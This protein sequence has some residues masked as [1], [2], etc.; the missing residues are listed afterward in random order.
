MQLQLPIKPVPAGVPHPSKDL[1]DA[2]P[3]FPWAESYQ[4]GEKGSNDELQNSML[5]SPLA[6]NPRNRRRRLSRCKKANATAF[7]Q[8]RPLVAGARYAPNRQL[9][10]TPFRSELVH[11][12]EQV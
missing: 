3:G 5:R 11:Y 7:R 12:T 2:F 6:P 10:L 9:L 4:K 8:W 1:C